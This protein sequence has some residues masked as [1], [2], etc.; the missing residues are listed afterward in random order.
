MT[1]PDVR[2]D[3]PV[4]SSHNMI[5]TRRTAGFIRV[6]TCPVEYKPARPVLGWATPERML[7]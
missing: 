4:D 1:S 2:T 7:P 6:R 3:A 5:S